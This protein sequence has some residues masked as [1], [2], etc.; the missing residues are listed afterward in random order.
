[1]RHMARKVLR[2]GGLGRGMR[3]GY[4]VSWQRYDIS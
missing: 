2:S 4:D 3:V 1:V